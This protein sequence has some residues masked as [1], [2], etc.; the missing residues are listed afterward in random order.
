MDDAREKRNSAWALLRSGEDPSPS[1]LRHS[2]SDIDDPDCTFELVAR[3]WLAD[4][5]PLWVP[6]NAF[7]VRSRLEKDIFPA[8]GQL[9][10]TAIDGTTVLAALRAIEARGAIETAKR[11]KGYVVAILKRAH[12]E[13]RI[14]AA[15]IHSVEC[16]GP[17]LKPALP[18]VR[19][20]ALTTVAELLDLQRAV[21]R[22]TAGSVIKL[23]SRLLALTVSRVGVLRQAVWSEFEG[24]DWDNEEEL[25]PGAIW[26]IPA[27][28][29]KLDMEDKFQSGF[30]HDVP[31]SRQAV[32]VLRAVRTLTGRFEY[33]FIQSRSWRD[34]VSDASLS[35]LYKRLGAGRY[36]NRMV[37]HGWRTAFSTILNERAATLN[38]PGDR[39]LIDMALAHVPEG[40][41]AS[42][43][44]Y[45]RARY[46]K[47]RSA[48][49]QA[50]ADII[51]QGLPPPGRLARRK[52]TPAYEALLELG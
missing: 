24:I 27:Q 17:A 5:E 19:L 32:D 43:W 7:R 34:P 38:R 6:A 10:V 20:P 31:L 52:V 21:D 13:G 39:L 41:S 50:W 37:P 40:V 47:P 48:L 2:G 4:Q 1:A 42:E 16:I 12:A 33:V 8:V 36:K 28:R 3:E 29:M 46:L 14:P 25:S 35:S 44:A 30:G 15:V 18:V 45:N 23:A 9:A 51:T 11:V 49:Y 26:R 22:S